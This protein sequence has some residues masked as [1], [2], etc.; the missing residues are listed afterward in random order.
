M[1]SQ[2]LSPQLE[3]YSDLLRIY[4]GCLAMSE[5]LPASAKHYWNLTRDY[6]VMY[7]D[8]TLDE[9]DALGRR[10]NDDYRFIEQQVDL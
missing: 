4:T 8:Y 1:S 9:F 3:D 6:Y 7:R 2:E 10:I 5:D